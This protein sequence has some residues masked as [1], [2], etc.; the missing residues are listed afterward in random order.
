MKENPDFNMEHRNMF[1]KIDFDRGVITL[2]GKEYELRDKNFPTV[3]KIT[4]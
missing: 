2:N 3:D 1:R 4:L